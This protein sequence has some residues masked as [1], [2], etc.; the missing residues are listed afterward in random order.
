[1]DLGSIFL[2]LALVLLVGWFVSRPLLEQGGPLA[3]AG[4]RPEQGIGPGTPPAG[5]VSDLSGEH[6]ALL[7]ERDRLLTALQELDFDHLLGKVPEEEYPLQR[8]ALLV[9]GAQVLKRLD[10]LGGSAFA[11]P[12]AAQAEDGGQL[13]SDAQLEAMIQ[14]R[15]QALGRP[16]AEGQAARRA[17]RPS[18]RERRPSRTAGKASQAQATFCPKCG[19]PVQGAD[20]FCS[21]CGAALS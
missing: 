4:S 10:E 7:A 18:R 13:L 6:S 16:Q 5:Q 2:I 15:R 12:P 3:N 9:A 1:M 21:H 17:S 20:R 8:R 14:A 19:K 11:E